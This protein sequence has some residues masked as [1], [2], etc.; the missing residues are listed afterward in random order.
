LKPIETYR[1]NVSKVYGVSIFA[2]PFLGMSSLAVL[3][4]IILPPVILYLARRHL[5]GYR[6]GVEQLPVSTLFS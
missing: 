3:Q 6:V 5:L 2:V 1:V 4:W